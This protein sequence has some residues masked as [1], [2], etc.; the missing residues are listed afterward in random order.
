MRGVRE[1]GLLRYWMPMYGAPLIVVMVSS[2]M[3]SSWQKTARSGRRVSNSQLPCSGARELTE[4]GGGQ[5]GEEA[6]GA[7]LLRGSA[8]DDVEGVRQG[9]KLGKEAAAR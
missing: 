8:E 5:H 3:Y 9:E 4:G 7:N 6:D 1:G 2:P